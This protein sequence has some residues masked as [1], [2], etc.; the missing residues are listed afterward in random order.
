M[1]I[2]WRPNAHSRPAM[3]P[4]QKW[5]MWLGITAS[6]DVASYVWLDRPIALFAHEHL[7]RYDLF[8]KL[9]YIPEI[10]SPVVILAFAAIG[11]WALSARTLSKL[12]TVAVL[13]AA[14]L[15]MSAGVKD[16]LKLAFGRTWPETWV[17]NNPSFIR[18]GVYG[19]NPFHGGPGFA[20]FPSG[21]TAAICAVMS[22]LW[23]CYPRYRVLYGICIGA[24]AIGLV[25]A[26]FHFLG[27]VFAG[28]FLGLSTGWL[29]VV[30][31][32]RGQHHLRPT[33]AVP[34]VD[35]SDRNLAPDF[36]YLV[37]RKAKEVG[38]VN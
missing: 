30:L 34:P 28:A 5:L 12:Q 22:V 16:Q 11:L 24:V 14:S 25:G 21:H 1:T 31:W 17:R 6:A 15:A 4:A 23:I 38:P 26:D 36:H 29:T 7:H 18:D 35:K 13:A 10:I 27:D 9:T 8:A 32:E 2:S 20:A 3:K 33:T 19:F 37:P